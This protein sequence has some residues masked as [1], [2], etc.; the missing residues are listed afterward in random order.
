MDA[1]VPLEGA[2][3]QR[4]PVVERVLGDDV[5]LEEPYAIEYHQ[6][7]E[8]NRLYQ[9]AKEE[10]IKVRRGDSTC[11]YEFW[12]KKWDEEK[13]RRRRF[14]GPYI[15]G[16]PIHP[17][18]YI[19]AG[20]PDTVND[21][22]FG[23]G[24]PYQQGIPVEGSKLSTQKCYELVVSS[25]REHSYEKRKIIAMFLK[26][27]VPCAK[28]NWELVE[29]MC[30]WCHHV[31]V[32]SKSTKKTDRLL[33]RTAAHIHKWL[34]HGQNK[35][36]NT[37]LTP[38]AFIAMHDKQVTRETVAGLVFGTVDTSSVGRVLQAKKYDYLNSRKNNINDFGFR[39]ATVCRCVASIFLRMGWDLPR[40]LASLINRDD[41]TFDDDSMKYSLWAYLNTSTLEEGNEQE[42]WDLSVKTLLSSMHMP[43]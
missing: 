5:C 38:I 6:V 32:L 34:S 13:D 4:P 23:A 21:L 8:H 15:D 16:K 1:A 26:N 31:G 11:R 35:K 33:F 22:Y 20:N 30:C 17:R 39:R 14:E 29:L 42:I 28:E 2:A 18:Q 10:L 41:V 24:T 40:Q 9:S 7:D 37:R 3:A 43:F 27:G 25:M 36:I 19:C 12:Q